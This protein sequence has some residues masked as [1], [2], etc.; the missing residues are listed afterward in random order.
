VTVT[1]LAG[2]GLSLQRDGSETLDIAASGNYQF[3][4]Q[5]AVGSPYAITIASQPLAPRQTCTVAQG[6]GTVDADASFGVTVN[7]VSPTTQF[8]YFTDV[9]GNN[10]AAFAFG[11]TGTLTTI[12]S[13]NNAAASYGAGLTPDGRFLYTANRTPNNI[14][15]Y[16]VD[17]STG[18]LGSVA[19]APFP[20]VGLAPRMLAIAPNGNFLYTVTQSG[21]TVVGFAVNR[22][23]GALTL[24]GSPTATGGQPLDV[25]ITPN[26]KYLYVAA[27]NDR[28]V[29]GYR[30][31]GTTGSL[32]P[33]PGSPFAVYDLST[34]AR[35]LSM[36]PRGRFLFV[37]TYSTSVAAM[38]ID[39]ATG[40]LTMVN[41]SPFATGGAQASF[42]ASDVSGKFLYVTNQNSNNLSAY[43]IEQTSGALTPLPGSPFSLGFAPQSVAAE[44][45]GRYLLVSGDS[46]RQVGVYALDAQTGV[47]TAVSGSPFSTGTLAPGA[48]AFLAR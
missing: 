17:T 38:N 37:P 18:A 33:V 9:G 45:G 32:T 30:I 25:T 23:N 19:G 10:L 3:A 12:G 20:V 48:I 29:Y 13:V 40:A 39:D 15:A 4:A 11:N 2:F 24:L 16:S 8:V 35:S 42:A 34:Y 14:G 26:A 7:C 27:F 41:G 31:D 5:V 47:P 22:T 43:S 21:N 46:T 36:D 6:F 28:S 1:G 44:P